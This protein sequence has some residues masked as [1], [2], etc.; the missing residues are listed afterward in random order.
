MYIKIFKTGLFFLSLTVFF[1]FSPIQDPIDKRVE[2]LLLKMSLEEKIG[3]MTQINIT[4]LMTDSLKAHYDSVQAFRLDTNKLISYITKYH[5]GSFLNGRG[6][7]AKSW[8]TYMDQL[9]RINMRYSRLKI[10]IIYGVDHVHGSNYL[11]E[12]TIF[13]HNINIA[14][15]FDTTFARQMGEVTIAETAGL[16]HNWIFAP[17][18]DLGRNKF[19]G[20]YYETY[21]EDPLLAS[22]MGSAFIRGIQQSKAGAYKATACAK[23]FIGYSDPKSGWDRS[24]A[25]IPDQILREFYLPSFKAAADAGVGTIMINSGELNG[26]PVH[27]SHEIL[28]KLLRNEL[29]F[30]G[31]AVTDWMDIIALQKMHFVAESEK[32]ATYM[33]INAG[34]DMAMTPLTTDFCRYVKELVKEGRITEERINLSVRRILKLKFSLGLFENPYPDKK[35]EDRLELVSNI[36]KAKQAARESIV[37][38]KNKEL[39]PLKGQK[40]ILVTGLCADRRVA[41]CGGWTYRFAPQSDYWFPPEMPT[42]YTALKT[43]F[44]RAKV[45]YSSFE[46]LTAKAQNA[47]VIVVVAGEE[48][49]Y[50]ETDGS[51]NDL[52]LSGNQEAW[53]RKAIDTGKPVVLV[54]TEGRP[55]I[56]S[57]VFDECQA[58]VFAGLPGGEGGTAIAQVLSGREN[59]SGKMSFTYPFKQGHIIPYNYKRSEYSALRPVGGELQRFAI[60]EFGYGLSYTTFAYSNL[61]LK[62]SIINGRESITATV[63]LS[64]TGSLPGKEAALWFISDDYA[65]ITRPV[66]ELAHFEKIFLQPGESRELSFV[67]KSL[68]DLSFPDKNGKVIL[69]NGGFELSVGGLKKKFYLKQ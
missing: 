3:Q 33:A 37:L 58:V 21:G 68:R 36:E 2:D 32:E 38:I 14:C 26:I 57:S 1:S 29:G 27:A 53:I 34:I 12:G 45:S 20:R 61:T 6:V 59:P 16:G 13:P 50:A 54:L 52:N 10:P 42:V 49:A 56:I 22:R 5:I 67:I 41:L 35:Y 55:R 47:D 65:S 30:K 63:T 51:I 17:V 44:N 64:N 28:T 60:A 62:D 46:E 19:W 18:M 4:M 24:P 23:H 69:E 43:E 11:K 48:L 25:E 40:N 7:E 31:V 9:S 66:K 8:F 39:L 15:T